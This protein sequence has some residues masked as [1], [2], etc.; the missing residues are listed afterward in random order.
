LKYIREQPQVI[1]HLKENDLKLLLADKD[2]RYKNLFETGKSNGHGDVARRALWERLMFG[3]C[4]DKSAS[5]LRPKY[6]CLNVTED[7]WGLRIARKQRYGGF[8]LVLKNSR[9]NH[10]R[11]TFLPCDSHWVDEE[12]ES[13]YIKGQPAVLPGTNECYGH[14]LL[15]YSDDELQVVLGAA[16]CGCD[17][18]SAPFRSMKEVEIHG[19][20]RFSDIESVSFPCDKPLPGDKSQKAQALRAL[21]L[22]VHQTMSCHVTWQGKCPWPADAVPPMSCL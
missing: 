6:G 9:V 1:V 14:V 10:A 20:L 22:K 21:E 16:G 11:M 4:Y 18:S 12:R 19:P 13:A 8:F 15:E 2:R 7:K 3:G 5:F 17:G